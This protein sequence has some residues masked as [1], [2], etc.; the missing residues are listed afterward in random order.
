M[1]MRA[2]MRLALVVLLTAML[3]LDACGTTAGSPPSTGITGTVTDSPASS[4]TA[5]Q[6]SVILTPSLA[7]YTA[8]SP[9]S[10][11][12]RNSL[13]SSIFALDNHTSCTVVQLEHSSDGRW[14]TTGGCVDGQPHP[15]IVEIKPGASLTIQLV[16]SQDLSLNGVWPSGTYRAELTYATSAT[17]AIGQGPTAYSSTFVVG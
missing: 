12:V 2:P 17:A 11:T 1:N 14:Q 15:R 6:Q 4:P 3:A 5:K 7:Q 16:P 13:S 8:S 10:V 9:I